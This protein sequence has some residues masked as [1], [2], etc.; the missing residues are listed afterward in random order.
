M[1][2]FKVNKELFPFENKFLELANGSKIHY[3]DEGRGAVLLMFHGNPSWSF[4]YRKMIQHLKRDFRCIAFDY[5]GFGLSEAPNGY[6]FSA[7]THSLVAE[8]FINKLKLEDVIIIGQDW[9]GPIGLGWAGRN[10]DKIKGAVLGN[11]WAWALAGNFRFEAFS[12]L[13]GGPIGRWM[14]RSFNGVWQFFMKRGFVKKRSEEEMAMY[15][16]PFENKSNRIQTA[17]FPRQLVKAKNFESEVE[18]GLKNFNDIPV[19]FSWGTEDFAFKA[20]E[21]KRFQSIFKNNE[22]VLL[23]ASHFWQDE[24]GEKASQ[25]IIQWHQKYFPK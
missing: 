19:L 23:D 2:K 1:T 3:I 22:T 21:R 20:P 14:A 12:W 17:I 11:T 25:A 15:K 5:P 8:E 16:A 18:K 4:L 7:K 13:M 10:P 24:A 9:G 6:D